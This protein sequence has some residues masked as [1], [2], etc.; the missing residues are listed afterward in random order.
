M[1]QAQVSLFFLRGR[2]L[3]ISP[4]A[5]DRKKKAGGYI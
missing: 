1:W 3:E 2:V 4:F 5:L